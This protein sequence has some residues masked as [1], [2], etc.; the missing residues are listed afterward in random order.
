MGPAH[1]ELPVGAAE[2]QRAGDSHSW[3]PPAASIGGGCC[4]GLARMGSSG[5]PPGVWSG[6]LKGVGLGQVRRGGFPG[7]ETGLLGRGYSPTGGGF[8]AGWGCGSPPSVNLCLSL[9]CGRPGGPGLR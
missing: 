7:R 2:R 9:L 4:R 3:R 1:P 8:S 5:Q 6:A